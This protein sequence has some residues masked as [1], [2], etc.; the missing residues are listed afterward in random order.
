MILKTYQYF[1]IINKKEIHYVITCILVYKRKINNSI[2]NIR[3]VITNIHLRHIR[4]IRPHLLDVGATFV[5]PPFLAPSPWA[6]P[7]NPPRIP[8]QQL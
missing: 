6:R 8:L 3:V 4:N 2:Y 1:Y 5:R 7:R